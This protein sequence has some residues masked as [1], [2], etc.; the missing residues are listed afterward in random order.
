MFSTYTSNNGYVKRDEW[1]VSIMLPSFYRV[2]VIIFIRER[3]ERF[4]RKNL[5]IT[6]SKWADHRKHRKQS[7]FY[8]ISEI[9]SILSMCIFH[10]CRYSSSSLNPWIDS[11]F[12][13][14]IAFD[15]T[16]MKLE[17][18]THTQQTHIKSIKPI[19]D[20]CVCWSV[21]VCVPVN[22]VEVSLYITATSANKRQSFWT[23][24]G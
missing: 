14:A 20:V 15:F 4:V 16:C 19:P 3:Y 18:Q 23:D 17:R 24:V 2:A 13:D 9:D 6:S 8:T 12:Y 7:F 10:N 1:L 11:G 5:D 21:Y 22:H